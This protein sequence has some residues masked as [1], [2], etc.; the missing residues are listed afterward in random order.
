MYRLTSVLKNA[1]LS[2]IKQMGGDWVAPTAP[3]SC[4]CPMML[5]CEPRRTAAPPK[6]VHSLWPPGLRAPGTHSRLAS[7]SFPLSPLYA[8]AAREISPFLV[9]TKKV[10]TQDT[11]SAAD[12]TTDLGCKC[13]LCYRNARNWNWLLVFPF[14][15]Y[16]LALYAKWALPQ[17]AEDIL[18]RSLP[19]PL[20]LPLPSSFLIFFF[21]QF[22]PLIS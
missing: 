11:L 6:G 4:P 18:V 15:K 16:F 20:P 3:A 22:S 13:G 9:T 14:K 1:L 19:S 10:L 2:L 17:K 5:P 7:C 8:R 21:L 12:F